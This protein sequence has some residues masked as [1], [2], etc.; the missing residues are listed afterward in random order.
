MPAKESSPDIPEWVKLLKK[1]LSEA[2]QE[3]VVEN[4]RKD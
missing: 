3:E 2:E 1:A 4:R